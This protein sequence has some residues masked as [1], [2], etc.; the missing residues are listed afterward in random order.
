MGFATRTLQR[1]GVELHVHF[2][3]GG[4]RDLPLYIALP[5]V[6]HVGTCL[7]K[8]RHWYQRSSPRRSLTCTLFPNANTR[9]ANTLLEALQGP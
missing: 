3:R 4:V 6:V 9:S 2:G 5:W 8:A 1:E 7:S